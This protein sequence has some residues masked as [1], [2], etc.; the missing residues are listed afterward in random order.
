MQFCVVHTVCMV[1]CTN[2]QARI[3][4]I[5]DCIFQNNNAILGGAVSL[6]G[7][8]GNVSR[9]HRLHISK[10]IPKCT[11]D[12]GAFYIISENAIKLMQI[13]LITV[14]GVAIYASNICDEDSSYNY[15]PRLREGPFISQE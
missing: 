7:I 6:E 14:R 4:S 3:V 10:P 9:H 12:G 13:L 15:N 2:Q 5:T 11:N 1:A 8:K